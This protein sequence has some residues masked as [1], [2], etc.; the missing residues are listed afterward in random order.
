MLHSTKSRNY[1]RY[2]I[3]HHRQNGFAGRI[4]PASRSLETPALIERVIVTNSEL[5]LMPT[6]HIQK[7]KRMIVSIDHTTFERSWPRVHN[8][9]GIPLDFY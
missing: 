6:I 9:F 5:I 3:F 7:P 2:I 4:W 1:R 8:L